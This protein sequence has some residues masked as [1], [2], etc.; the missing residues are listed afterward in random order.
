MRC[1]GY[2]EGCECGACLDLRMDE[3]REWEQYQREAQQEQYDE[4]AR[5]QEVSYWASVE[6]EARQRREA[7][8]SW[9][10]VDEE[11]F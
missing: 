8:E 7:V 1:C 11:P 6:E 4:W 2:Q 10:S 9:K 3:Q 5:D